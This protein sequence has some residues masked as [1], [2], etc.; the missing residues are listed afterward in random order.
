MF[1]NIIIQLVEQYGYL[2]FFLAFSLGPFGIPVP[3]EVTKQHG[4]VRS[5]DNIFLHLR[6]PVNSIHNSLFCRQ[7]FR[8]KYKHKT[9]K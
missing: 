1:S 9:S 7:N 6:W 4:C 2:A 5:L 8:R 3:N